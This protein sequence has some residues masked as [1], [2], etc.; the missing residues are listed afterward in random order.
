MANPVKGKL[1]YGVSLLLGLG[2]L[3]GA[4]IFWTMVHHAG[5]PLLPPI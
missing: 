2:A 4:Y 3:V 5:Q 1:E